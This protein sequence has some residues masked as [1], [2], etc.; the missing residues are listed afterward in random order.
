MGETFFDARD[1]AMVA[2]S[3][4]KSP[5]GGKVDT[6]FTPATQRLL[7]WDAEPDLVFPG[8]FFRMNQHAE[9]GRAIVAIVGAVLA[10]EKA[11]TQWR[12]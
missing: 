12:P 10:S 1:R 5:S 2:A 6:V 3:F 7:E 9:F 8:A 4:V 11:A